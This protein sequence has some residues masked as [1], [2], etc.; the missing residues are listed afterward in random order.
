MLNT[1]FG[2]VF[3]NMNE[4]SF[5]KLFRLYCFLSIFARICSCATRFWCFL[6][7]LEST[8]TW[9]GVAG[10]FT[11][12]AARWTVGLWATAIWWRGTTAST[13]WWWART[14]G[15]F[16]VGWFSTVICNCNYWSRFTIKLLLINSNCNIT[17][18]LQDSLEQYWS[19]H[20]RRL[21]YS[22]LFYLR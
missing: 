1:A 15:T 21:S 17:W 22:Y 10:T 9:C 8:L 12:A 16:V 6:Q 5:Y 7:F 4:I 20:C 19:W 13:T 3:F 18:F 2:I 11:R 14:T